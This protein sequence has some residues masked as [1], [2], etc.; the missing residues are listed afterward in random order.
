MKLGIALGGGVARSIANIGVLNVL[1]REGIKLDYIAG[2]SAASI[3]G[4][5]YASGVS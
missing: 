4:A 2:T 1:A 5:I 3:I